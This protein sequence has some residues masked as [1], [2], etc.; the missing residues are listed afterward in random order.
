MI[1]LKTKLK[2]RLKKY[3]IVKKIIKIREK[4]RIRKEFLKEYKYFYEYYNMPNPTNLKKQYKMLLN[5]HALEK[6]ML[7]KKMRP[8]G[9]EKVN[10][11]IELFNEV[12]DKDSY[13]CTLTI[14]ILKAYVDVYEKNG[15]SSNE[16]Y[17]KVKN[18]LDEHISNDFKKAGTYNLSKKEIMKDSEIN[19]LAFLSGRH[20]V[21]SF[22]NIPLKEEDIKN[23]VNMAIMSP[24]ACNRQ[25]CKIWHIIDDNKIDVLKKHLSGLGNFNLDNKISFF[26]ITFDMNNCLF[27]SDRHDGRFNAGLMAMNFVNGLH[28]LGIGSC[29]LQFGNTIDDEI[30][31]KKVLGIPNNDRIA[32]VI[33][34]G[35]YEDEVKVTYSV[36][37]DINDIFFE[38]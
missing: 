15:W 18:F 38:K 19:Y 31:V 5:I 22:K 17:I 32:I 28:S 21:R 16:E 9:V 36:R 3:A 4:R 6:G 27:L 13:A 37:K 23:A 1:K 30:E 10:Q 33:A 25:M 29:F 20:S 34:A 7:N 12:D 8:F 2:E 14:G 24:S 11:L 35:Y 26:I